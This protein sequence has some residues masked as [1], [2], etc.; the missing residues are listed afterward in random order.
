MIWVLERVLKVNL[1]QYSSHYKGCD[2]PRDF[3]ME[4]DMIKTAILIDGAFYRK[5]AYY[6]WG[7][8]SPRERANELR[9]YCN[10]H[11]KR[12][13][14]GAELYRV[15]Y[16]DCPPSQK[17]I[18]NPISTRVTDLGITAQ[19]QWTM[20][21]YKELKHQRKFALRLGRLAEEQAHYILKDSALK[22]LLRGSIA[23]SDLSESD[24]VLE[25]KQKGVDMRIG[26]DISS[27]AFKHQVDRIVLIS[28]DSDF[29]PAAKQARREGVDF[30]L[31]SMRQKVKDDLYEHIDGMKTFVPKK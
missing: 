4:T 25:I 5:R 18:Y 10:K 29:V 6:F 20:D 11:I 22:K 23:V 27:L 19:Y 3:F 31:D 1:W 2:E 21:F 28:G 9:E 30:V 13:K 26:I 12:E 17:K 15:F 14:T 7:D 8:K 16:Y 24:L